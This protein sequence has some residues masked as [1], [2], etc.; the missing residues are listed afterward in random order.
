[1]LYFFYTVLLVHV[2]TQR[3][4]EECYDGKT[5]YEGT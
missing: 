4:E 1:M 5:F 2:H 3:G